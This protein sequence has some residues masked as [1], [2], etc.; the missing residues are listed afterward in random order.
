[1]SFTLF[2]TIRLLLLLF[3]LMRWKLQHIFSTF[4]PPNSWE[5]SPRLIFSIKKPPLIP[6]YAYLVICVI[7]SSPLQKFI[8]YNL[9]P[10]MCIFW[11][12]LL[13]IGATNVTILPPI[14][15]FCFAM[16]CL[17]SQCSVHKTNL[18]SIHYLWL[19]WWNMHPA[20]IQAI[21]HSSL[22]SGLPSPWA[23][24]SQACSSQ[25]RSCLSQIT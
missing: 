17:M 21:R 9:V 3:G 8:S 13:L 1:M 16:W 7:P 12:I 18:F 10:Q 20:L 23:P 24:S 4:C 2:S 19:S 25:A 6:T 5:T 14:K 15:L 11:V 22:P